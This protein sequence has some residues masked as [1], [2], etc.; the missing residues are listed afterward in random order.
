MSVRRSTLKPVGTIFGEIRAALG[1]ATVIFGL[2]RRRTLVLER[3]R[4]LDAV[5]SEAVA[6]L[7]GIRRVWNEEHNRIN[8]RAWLHTDLLRTSVWRAHKGGLTTRLDGGP[9]VSDD[10]ATDLDALCTEF[11]DAARGS[12][13]FSS[14]WESRLVNIAA[15]LR[16]ELIA[17][18]DRLLDRLAS[19]GRSAV[20][21]PEIDMRIRTPRS[22]EEMQQRALRQLP[23]A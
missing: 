13:A 5:L 15:R 14:D 20:A 7:G 8:W 17:Y 1:L 22:P 2:R 11:D 12:H 19:V 10:L 23:R 3:R 6:N 4:Q 21:A 16:E 18:P 9:V